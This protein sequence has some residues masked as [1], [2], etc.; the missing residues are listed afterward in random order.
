M[1]RSF[2]FEPPEPRPG[3]L[4]RPRL[5]RALLGRWEH[6][7]TSV[8]G[9]PGL[10]K[11]T[12]LAQAV[13]EN[14]LAPRGEDVWIG[15]EEGDANGLVLA[16]DVMAAVSA[17]SADRAAGMVP[18]TRDEAPDP[19]T[20]AD[21]V[22]RRA[23]TAVCLVVDDVHWLAPG[24]WAATWLS[25]LVDGLPANGHVLLASRW[26]PAVPLA[27]LATQGAVLRLAEDDLRFSD[28]ELAAFA[29]RR[30]I[31]IGRFD[32]T[33]GWPAMAELV[34]S[35]GHDLAGDYLWEEVL[36]PLGPERRRVLAV[37]SDLEGADDGLAG[38][39]LGA[40]VDLARVLNGVPLVANGTGGWRVPH[41]LWH[42]VPALALANDERV[43]TRRRAVDHLVAEHRYDEAVTLA[44]DAG[45]VDLLP[46][47]LR[48]ACIGGDRPPGR[49]LDRWLADLP[50]GLRDTAGAALAAGVRAAVLAPAEATEPLQ[51]AIRRCREAGDPDGELG[52]VAL[53][54]EVAWWGGDL[55]LL[56][57]LLPR[58]VELAAEGH[59]LARALAALGQA[60]LADIVGG[61]D[62]VLAHLDA[63]DPGVFDDAWEAMA[64][65]M[66]ATTLAGG[67]RAEESITVIEAIP[68]VPDPALQLAVEGAHLQAR[69]ALGQVDEVVAAVPSITDRFEAA[70]VLQ[71]VLVSLAEAAFMFAWVGD[72]DAARRLVA[73]V[74][75]T[76]VDVDLGQTAR[77][78]LAEAGMLVTAGDEPAA[79]DLLERAIPSDGVDSGIDRR[80]WRRG[81]ALTYV[82]VPSA[83]DRWDAAEL[84]GG[85]AEARTLARAVVALRGC[86]GSRGSGARDADEARRHLRDLDLSDMSRVRAG[87]HH[88]FAVDLALGLEAAGRPEG[89]ALL[90]ALG[91]RGRE[92]LRAEA[93]T[94]THRAKHAKSLLAA[95]PAPPADVTEIAALGPLALERNGEAVT[96]GDLRR[97]RVRA[98]LAFLV[99]HRTTSRAAILA[100]LW[101]DLDERAAANNL[102][103]TMTYLLRVLEPWRSGRE[104]AYHV[105]VDG[106][107][108]KLVTGDWLRIDLDRFDEHV[109]RAAQAEADG[110][111][112]L[113]L[114]HNLAAAALY[115]GEAH[116]GVPDADWIALEREHFRVR[117][118]GAAT[119]AGELLVARGDVDEAERVARRAVEVDPWAE[120]AHAVLVSVALARGDRSAAR[121]GLDRGLAALA[122]LGVEP[123]EETRRLRRRVRSGGGETS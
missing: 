60:V 105:R 12:L 90:E 65:W 81:L 84:R 28:E 50:E 54:C 24:S 56:A 108:V 109:A 3:S 2:R 73:R 107:A 8:V 92:D 47:I 87:L 83:R 43:S 77:L 112:S 6:R 23:P 33:G 89:A 10:G 68:P 14:R 106:Q 18:G 49:Q 17:G 80:V 20:V 96:D 16:R 4:T 115:R 98:L 103:V 117:F 62:D 40:P 9:G 63:I 46:G 101:P 58:V 97:E 5:L 31:A 71:F 25:A 45:L 59:P 69:W 88:R 41:P 44:R 35:V 15:L 122:E 72:V 36:E 86:T 37:L 74:R 22:W 79:A 116:E 39:A 61:D 7:V 30:G 32:D 19:A 91:P 66:R 48:A 120:D 11:T 121:R 13:A 113:A 99:G 95:V 38:A 42:G 57:G 53:L 1:P 119:R 76:E 110:T 21:A 55:G 78:A 111:P 26:S 27:R 104:S 100:A 67:G 29:A 118:V 64:G 82:L 51:T 94:R 75:R 85:V 52:A 70:G 114:E 123:S 102:R 34:A 93:A